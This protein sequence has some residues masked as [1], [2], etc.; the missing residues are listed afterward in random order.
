MEP[1]GT[2]DALDPA[3]LD[4]ARRRRPADPGLRPCGVEGRD[5]L[6]DTGDDLD[7]PD[8]ADVQDGSEDKESP[9]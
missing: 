2:V 1:P 4:V 3:Q 5:R 9:A 7:L 6:D 8:D